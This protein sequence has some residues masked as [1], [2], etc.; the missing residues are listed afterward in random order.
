[1]KPY[2]VEFRGE[3]LAACDTTEERR[4]IALRFNVSESWLRRIQQ[5]RRETGQVGPK[6][7]APRQPKWHAWAGWLVAKIAARPDIYLRELQA[8]L[9]RELGEEVCLGTICAACRA[10]EQSR[11]K[12]P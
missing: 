10:L 12:R 9:K 3:V 2:D 5:Q 6:T 1:M 4:A 11:K 7:A 8:E